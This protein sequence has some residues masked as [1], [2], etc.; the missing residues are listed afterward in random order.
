MTNETPTCGY[1]AGPDALAKVLL[2]IADLPH[3]A[4]YLNRNQLHRGRCVVALR[5]HKTEYFQLGKEEN[6]GF[7]ADVA[8]VAK[9]LFELFAPQK[10]NYATFG[11]LVP[12]AHVH[13][14]PKYADGPQ[15]GAP[16]QDEPKK[17]LEDS[18]YRELIGRIKKE[19]EK[20]S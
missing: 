1:C 10:I 15:W 2:K 8:L 4:V 13:I 9:V 17:F 16:F 6:A 3:S 5:E 20:G 12:H 14:V 19:L 18:E 11:D 7:F